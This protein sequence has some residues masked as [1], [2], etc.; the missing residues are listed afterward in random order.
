LWLKLVNENMLS[1]KTRTHS[2]FMW[3]KPTLDGN[4][5]YVAGWDE[6]R[7][8]E[9]IVVYAITNSSSKPLASARASLHNS[10]NTRKDKAQ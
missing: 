5:L 10:P 4:T 9:R 1:K 2:Y 8:E 6:A 7:D 3:S